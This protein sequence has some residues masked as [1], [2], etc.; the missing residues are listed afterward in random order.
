MDPRKGL[1][2]CGLN[3]SLG[4]PL[5]KVSNLAPLSVGAGEYT[6]LLISQGV[7]I[8]TIKRFSS[9]ELL[10]VAGWRQLDSSLV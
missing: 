5:A 4:D 9:G 1:A 8:R 3:L 2:K 6:N 7:T 10:A